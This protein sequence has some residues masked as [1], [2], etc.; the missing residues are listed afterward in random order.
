MDSRAP[1]S[2][3][4]RPGSVLWRRQRPDT[5]AE[6]CRVDR[7]S[8]TAELEIEH[9]RVRQARAQPRPV[10]LAVLQV[11]DTEVGGGVELMVRLVVRDH[12]DWAVGQVAADVL[13]ARTP[14][15]G[16]EDV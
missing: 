9:G 2:L 11:E 15:A 14:V 13:P 16:F 1:A 10:L 8:V 4:D 5:A 6:G 3:I 7:V 12:L